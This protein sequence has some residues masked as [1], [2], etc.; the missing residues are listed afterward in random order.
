VGIVPLDRIIIGQ[1]IR[2][3]DVVLGLR[4]SGIHSN[5]LTL[6]RDVF[7][8]RRKLRPDR[9]MPELGRTIGD[10]LLEP[11]RI[12][13]PEV[14]EMLRDKLDLKALIHMTG[15]GLLNLSRVAAPV[16]FVIDFWPEPHPIFG[17]IRAMG[18]IGPE[19]MFRVFNMGIGFC[20]V[21]PDDSRQIDRVMA[22]AKRHGVECYRL[23]YAIRDAEQ[24]ISLKPYNLVGHGGRFRRGSRFTVRGSQK[25]ERGRSR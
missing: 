20:L 19:E 4:S 6:A 14:I 16:G 8:R 11:T 2:P 7:F 18:R 12:Y 13:V 23:G 17:L 25:G 22:I 3:K 24:R 9:H 5:G 10:E 15:D 21:L 1:R